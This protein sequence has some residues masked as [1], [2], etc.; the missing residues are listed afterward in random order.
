MHPF[1]CAAVRALTKFGTAIAASNPMIGNI[2]RAAPLMMVPVMAMP[3]PFSV[4]PDFFTR[5]NYATQ[6]CPA[7]VCG[8]FN[9]NPVLG[10]RA[11][12]ENVDDQNQIRTG[13][14]FQAGGL[15]KSQ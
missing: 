11:A 5:E 1:L 10:K 14:V 8:K 12:K 7:S 4:P 6:S 13:D 15:V 9:K 3:W 2:T